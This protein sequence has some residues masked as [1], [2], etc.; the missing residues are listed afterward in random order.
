MYTP[1]NATKRETRLITLLPSHLSDDIHCDLDV[2]SLAEAPLYSAL[3]YVWG[4]EQ[5]TREVFVQGISRQVTS[6]LETCL[7]HLRSTD[8]PRVLWIDAICINQDDLPERSAQVAQMGMIYKFAKDVIAWL[9]E[10]SEDSRKAFELIEAGSLMSYWCRGSDSNKAFD[11]EHVTALSNL[12]NRPWWNRVWTF[13][14][15][16]LAKHAIFACGKH[17]LDA[18][19]FFQLSRTYFSHSNTCNKCD[20]R[21][22][23]HQE[24]IIRLNETL[25]SLAMLD[26]TCQDAENSHTPHVI[27]LYRSREC[28]DPRD[29]IYG[30]MGLEAINKSPSAQRKTDYAASVSDVYAQAAIDLIFT[31]K[32]LA[33][34]SQLLPRS[35]PHRGLVTDEIPSWAPDW[36]AWATQ[37]LSLDIYTRM[38]NLRL[39]NASASS[40]IS[41]KSRGLRKLFV[42]GRIVGTIGSMSTAC[43]WNRRADANIYYEWRHFARV[44]ERYEEPYAGNANMTYGNAFWHAL[45]ASVVPAR[46]EG[47]KD[48]GEVV[49]ADS[50]KH[51]AVHDS[52]W[53][54][55]LPD[56]D[57]EGRRYLK[58][59][60]KIP[61]IG[62]SQFLNCIGISTTMRRLFVE[63]KEHGWMGLVP[64]D[65]EENDR[66]AVIEG[67]RVP[68]ILRPSGKES[69][70]WT[71]VGDAYVHGIMDGEGMTLG[72][73]QEIIL[74]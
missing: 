13:Q 6:N 66:I 17:Q 58:P 33:V 50:Q 8:T 69:G 32:Q 16:I 15:L 46:L 3:S 64:Q 36:T 61:E 57:I 65:A 60:A 67:G 71:L 20:S 26:G 45:C 70:C 47:V 68:Y 9:G 34:F 54:S 11:P 41:A 55:V 37:Q 25:G 12:I 56:D 74:V 49:R 22:N 5:D 59:S 7:R 2:V 42:K 63:E 31:E 14:E 44:D 53:D 24:D 73:L 1:L 30:F 28:K 29:K 40:S 48:L 72:E 27:A 18:A 4:S 52:W 39:Y 51:R 10:E 43:P 23:P 62:I 38:T 35:A 21:R 19:V